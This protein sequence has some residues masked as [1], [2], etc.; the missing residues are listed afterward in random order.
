MRVKPTKAAREEERTTWAF[1]QGLTPGSSHHPD[2]GRVASPPLGAAPLGQLPSLC[3]LVLCSQALLGA[4]GPRRRSWRDTGRAVRPRICGSSGRAQAAGHRR[5]GNPALAVCA[6]VPAPCVCP[7]FTFLFICLRPG[8]PGD[9]RRTK[10]PAGR[11][12]ALQTPSAHGA[13]P[14]PVLWGPSMQNSFMIFIPY[15]C[16][17]LLIIISLFF[18][19]LNFPFLKERC[20]SFHLYNPSP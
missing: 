13:K 12:S 15:H 3:C 6:G 20:W 4:G 11:V 9:V 5:P 16:W 7:T 19:Y 17:Y 2:S 1:S 10:S 8:T 14:I 18:G